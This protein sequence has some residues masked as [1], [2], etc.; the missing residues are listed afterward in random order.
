MHRITQRLIVRRI[1]YHDPSCFDHRQPQENQLEDLGADIEFSAAF[2]ATADFSMEFLWACHFPSALIQQTIAEF[3]ES[4]YAMLPKA[5]L[6]AL[7]LISLTLSRTDSRRLAL[8]VNCLS[9]IITRADE[10]NDQPFISALAD[11][12]GL[13]AS[14]FGV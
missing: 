11:L 9:S 5:E 10:I 3:S 7:Q 1:I 13:C 8:T 6:L 14:R 4:R 2:L 12:V